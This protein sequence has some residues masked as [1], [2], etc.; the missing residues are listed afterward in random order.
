MTNLIGTTPTADTAQRNGINQAS[1]SGWGRLKKILLDLFFPLKCLVCGR[2]GV[3]LCQPCLDSFP[4]QKFFLCPG[5]LKPSFQGQTH[6]DCQKNTAL[7]GL[8]VASDWQF[9]PLK[10]LIHSLKYNFATD[11]S[12]ILAELIVKRIDQSVWFKKIIK[13]KKV[14]LAPVPLH[15]T[16]LRQRGFNQS[17][18]IAEC[19]AEKFALKLSLEL[20]RKNKNTLPQAKLSGAKRRK[21]IV[22]A[23]QVDEKLLGG[24]ETLIILDDVITTGSTLNECAKAVKQIYPLTSV[25]ALAVAKG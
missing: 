10:T 6:P 4:L 18:L 15:R 8:L 25:W 2:Y 19:L 9:K 22:G 5:C 17:A 21:N 13:D 11:I 7:D 12:P 1:V 3:W 14:T 23:Y 24:N 16:K 20:L